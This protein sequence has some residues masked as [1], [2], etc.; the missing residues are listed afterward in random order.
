MQ[1]FFSAK[2]IQ[3]LQVGI[4]QISYRFLA[5]HPC[6]NQVANYILLICLICLVSLVTSSELFGGN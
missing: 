2:G 1:F 6:K 4:C 3:S 5:L